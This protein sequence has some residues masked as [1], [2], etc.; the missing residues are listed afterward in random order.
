MSDSLRILLSSM[1]TRLFKQAMR[2]QTDGP[3]FHDWYAL[4]CAMDRFEKQGNMLLGKEA[5][6]RF[7]NSVRHAASLI[8]DGADELARVIDEIRVAA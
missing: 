3:A 2:E 5:A 8:P 6:E 4:R 1:A 7:E